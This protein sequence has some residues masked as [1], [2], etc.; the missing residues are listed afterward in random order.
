MP[1]AS[2]ADEAYAEVHA[3]IVEGRLQAGTAVTEGEFAEMLG[4]SR[5]PVRQVLTR[6][7]L[8]GYLERD[9]RGRLLV[10]ALMPD[11]LEE[12]FLVR[13]LLEGFG[14]R[15]AAERISEPEL[16]RL[17]ELLAIDLEAGRR[18]RVDELATINAEFHG[19]IMRASRNRAL[20]EVADDLAQRVFGLNAFAVGTPTDV[21]QFV[22][23]HALMVRLLRGGEAKALEALVHKHLSTARDLLVKG[24]HAS[25]S[26][27][28]ASPS[29]V[30]GRAPADV[31]TRSIARSR[32]GGG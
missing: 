19:L 30:D 29:S 9:P 32:V 18:N 16:E 25:A 1:R 15:L 10:H 23:E 31:A 22:D 6:L 12:M 27:Q 2:L 14:A 4:M 5:T 8:E 13:A 26:G 21:R 11:E 24:L 28:P 7:E 3:A 17:E 20:V